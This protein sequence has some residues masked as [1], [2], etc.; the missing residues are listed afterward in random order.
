MIT[1]YYE[2]VVDGLQNGTQVWEEYWMDTYNNEVGI[3]IGTD[4]A[5]SW[6]EVVGWARKSLD[7]ARNGKD[8]YA[9]WLDEDKWDNGTTYTWPPTEE[10]YTKGPY[11][12]LPVG[13]DGKVIDP[14]PGNFYQDSMGSYDPAWFWMQ[15]LDMNENDRYYFF[16]PAGAGTQTIEDQTIEDKEG[17]NTVTINWIPLGSFLNPTEGSETYK[18]L[19]IDPDTHESVFTAQFV[20]GENGNYFVV[21]DAATNTQVRL[22]DFQEGDFGIWFYDELNPW[23]VPAT[24]NTILGDQDPEDLDDALIDTADNDLILC[25]DGDD[26][27]T[28]P[29]GGEDW[30]KGEDGSDLIDAQLSTNCIIEGGADSDVLFGSYI[31]GS[32]I[33][34]DIFGEKE[35]L[36]E[37]GETAQGTDEKGD[38]IAGGYP[39]GDNFLYGS[40]GNDIL[41][42]YSGSDLMVGG[43]GDDLIR[44]RLCMLSQEVPS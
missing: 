14:K 12:P 43:G 20:N 41:L 42:A 10:W 31:S 16:T 2:L 30:I 26:I 39:G 29:T 28:A 21:T 37:A 15:S 32:Q 25:G 5:Y 22:E 3:Y 24:S 6:D 36:I 34:A 38:L 44:N 7:P 1:Q 33:F 8:G 13:M 9:M 23:A 11:R 17:D 19:N 40:N 18:S 4:L 35:D 27:V